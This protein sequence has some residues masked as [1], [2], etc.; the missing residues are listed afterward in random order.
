MTIELFF[1]TLQQSIP[2][3]PNLLKDLLQ[4]ISKSTSSFN[5][6]IE[7]IQNSETSR[8]RLKNYL[9]RVFTGKD[10]TYI[11]V[12][13]G[14]PKRTGFI[15]EITRKI[16]HTLIPEYIDKTTF[17]Q[18]YSIISNQGKFKLTTNQLSQL[19]N[20]LEIKINFSQSYLQSELIDAIE[21]LSYR[22]TATAIESEFIQKFK[23]NKILDSFIKQNKEIHALIAQH[24]LGIQ[25]NPHLVNHVQKLLQQSMEDVDTLKKLSSNQGASL[26]LTYS[27]NRISHQ[28]KR[29]NLL[30]HIY[31]KPILTTLELADFLLQISKNERKNNSIRDQLNETSYLLANQITEHES[32]TGEHYIAD[33]KKEYN[34]M[35]R[36]SCGGGFF[37]S[38]MTLIKIILQH[39][40]LAPFWQ[41]FAYSINY[42]SGFVGIQITHA[43][44]ATK[45]PAMTASRIA[46][47]LHKKDSE[48]NPMEGLALMIGK[49]SRSQFI[50]FVGNLL[51]VFPL[52]FA[53]AW[54]Y[55][56]FSGHNLVTEVEAKKMLVDVH[57]YLNPTWFYACITGVYLFL[58]GIISG[59]YDN[60]VIYSNIPL[61]VRHHPLLKKILT[62]RM[63]IK[64]SIFIKHNLGGL[65]GNIALG[66]FWG[67]LRFLDLFLA[68]H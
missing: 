36:S 40:S 5:Q 3:H 57:P 44:L 23:S 49:V 39:L 22:I 63:L 8:L 45:Q 11:L 12:E 27:L 55:A 28:I 9:E 33:T 16:K 66:F 19:I 1:T 20:I 42:A 47:S 17:H 4:L 62:K 26:Q 24:T 2:K 14:I 6:L 68:Y 52:S 32:N 60:K 38:L 7:T 48:D 37:A 54:L 30:L 35:F 18:T 56:T 51:V 65:I 50:S 13:S 58:S 46:L 59:Y 34:W 25:F 61:R 10:I 64:F 31:S 67:Q 15:A 41:A 21:I 43:T 29:L 53:I